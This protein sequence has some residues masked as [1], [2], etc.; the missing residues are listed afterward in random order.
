MIEIATA[1]FPYPKDIFGTH[2]DML[3]FIVEEPSPTLPSIFSTQF[4]SFIDSCLLKDHRKR[5]NATALL[6]VSFN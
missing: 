5:P 4:K 2:F 6:V 1:V 3:P